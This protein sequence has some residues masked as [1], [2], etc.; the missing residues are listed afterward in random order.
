MCDDL[1]SDDI[2]EHDLRKGGLSRRELGSLALGAGL[3]FALPRVGEC[4]GND[5]IRGRDQDARTA[6]PMP[7]S[8]IRRPAGIRPC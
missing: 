4:R 1:A 7:T 3:A 6:P 2:I 8:C 5:G